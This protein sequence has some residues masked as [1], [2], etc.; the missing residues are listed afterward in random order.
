MYGEVILV[1]YAR[2][3]MTNLSRGTLVDMEMKYS[4]SYIPKY[5]DR[6]NKLDKWNLLLKFP[7][8]LILLLHYEGECVIDLVLPP[9]PASILLGLHFLLIF[10]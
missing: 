8:M 2:K 7:K 1:V 5:L 6:S 10:H 4:I 3:R 9:Y